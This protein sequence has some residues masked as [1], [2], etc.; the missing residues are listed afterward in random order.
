MGPS[1]TIESPEIAAARAARAAQAAL[2]AQP[3]APAAPAVKDPLSLCVYTT[4][5]LLAW[6]F[7]PPLTVAAFAALGLWAYGRAWRAGLRRSNCF[8][9]DPR[10]VMLYLAVL[11]VAGLAWP[12]L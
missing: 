12:L 10:L 6:L 1:E 9:R 2:S 11:L 4:V 5:A 3:P 8:L 7:S